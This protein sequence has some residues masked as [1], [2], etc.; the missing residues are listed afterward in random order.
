MSSIT[1]ASGLDSGEVKDWVSIS[2]SKFLLHLTLCISREFF[3]GLKMFMR[4]TMQQ[5][6]WL[7]NEI[8]RPQPHAPPADIA[9]ITSAL[10]QPY[11]RIQFNPWAL[12]IVDYLHL[13]LLHTPTW[14]PSE[15]NQMLQVILCTLLIKTMNIATCQLIKLLSRTSALCGLD[16][17][18]PINP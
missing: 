3:Y 13:R 4:W 2:F 14:A 18:S 15:I 1:E 5:C 6:L 8:W 9:S 11:N 12:L 10:S 7:L 17:T 16:P